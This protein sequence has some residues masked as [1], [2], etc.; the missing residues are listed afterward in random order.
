MY[1]ERLLIA[2]QL[3]PARFRIVSSATILRSRILE[4]SM[5]IPF[6]WLPRLN[7]GPQ[8]RPAR[9]AGRIAHSSPRQSTK[10]SPDLQIRPVPRDRRSRGTDRRARYVARAGVPGL[11]MTAGIAVL[12]TPVSAMAPPLGPVAWSSIAATC[13]SRNR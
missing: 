5:S 12:P 3:E 2:M 1:S 4:S 6:S 13:V 7:G 9:W 8:K 10:L 11:V